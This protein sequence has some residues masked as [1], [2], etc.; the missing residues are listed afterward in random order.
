MVVGIIVGV[1]FG[2]I[3]TSLVTDIIM[4]PIGLMLGGVDFNS[5]FFS[6]DGKSYA[7]LALAKAASAP[8]LN[9]GVFINTILDFLIVAFVMFLSVR[10]MN[11]L[12]P[13]DD[14]STKDCPF[15]LSSIPIKATRCAQC[16]SQLAA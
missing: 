15:C 7:T 14:P 4:P 5:L 11:Q 2:K 3:I 1:A 8:T 6:L 12:T 9:Y 16:T 13:P 10:Q